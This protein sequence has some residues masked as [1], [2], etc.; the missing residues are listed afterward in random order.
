LGR[1]RYYLIG[2]DFLTTPPPP[3][4][5]QLLMIRLA[6]AV[7]DRGTK[8]GVGVLAMNPAIAEIARVY[9]IRLYPP[10]ELPV[11]IRSLDQPHQAIDVFA[12][13]VRLV[14]LRPENASHPYDFVIIT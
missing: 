4:D 14:R 7:R 6:E 13:D 9:D 8:I 12:G 11:P 2:L 3:L 10:S 5:A 1:Q